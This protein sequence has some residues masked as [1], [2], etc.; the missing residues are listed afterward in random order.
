MERASNLFE[1][2]MVTTVVVSVLELVV[3]VGLGVLSDC[4]LF[5]ISARVF[6]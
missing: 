5:L 4:R 2:S 1:V 3:C 6:A